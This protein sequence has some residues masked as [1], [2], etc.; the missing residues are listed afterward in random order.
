MCIVSFIGGSQIIAIDTVSYETF[1]KNYELS[2]APAGC[3][4]APDKSLESRKTTF[5]MVQ[6]KALNQ[7]NGFLYLIFL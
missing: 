6:Y 2:P 1:L 7:F 5:P 3:V 4:V